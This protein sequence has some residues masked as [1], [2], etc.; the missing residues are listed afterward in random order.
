VWR[1]KAKAAIWGTSPLVDGRLIFGDKAGWIHSI[2][3]ED[4]EPGESCNCGRADLKDIHIK[5]VAKEADK[6][7]KTKFVVFEITPRWEGQLGDTSAVRPLIVGKWVK[8]TGY[9][10]YDYKHRGNARNRKKK[11]NI[12]RATAWEVHPVT[13]FQVVPSP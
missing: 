1:F 10:T 3:A 13:A 8:F 6:D 9:L 4:G 7:D 2:S 11:G 5:V 12:W